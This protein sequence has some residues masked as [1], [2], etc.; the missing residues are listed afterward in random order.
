MRKSYRRFQLGKI[1]GYGPVVLG[2]G[3]RLKYLVRPADSVLHE[4]AILSSGFYGHVGNAEPVVHGQVCK[5]ISHKFQR[6]VKG[7]VNSDLSYQM[8]DHIFSGNIFLRLA[9]QDY[10]DGC[11]H[12]EPGFACGHSGG[13]VGASHSCGKGSQSAV[14]A[15]VGIRSDYALSGGHKAFFRQQ[16]VFNAHVAHIVEVVYIEFSGKGPGLSALLSGL[17][18]FVGNEMVHY[19]RYL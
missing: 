19:Q 12:L 1:Y 5:S 7:S 3:I 15:C 10:L 2:V 6:F 9:G 4:Y 8:E 17:D 18:V 16:G 11:R 14:G 13:H